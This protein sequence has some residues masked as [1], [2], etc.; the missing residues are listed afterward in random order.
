[1]FGR[2]KPVVFDRYAS[3][4]SR[5]IMPRWLWLLLFGAALGAGGVI[6]VQQEHLPQ[7]LS[8][9]ES[10]QL[11]TAFE[12]AESERTRLAAELAQSKLDRETALAEAKRLTDEL[13]VNQRERVALRGNIEAVL[14]S[15][16]PDPRGGAVEVRSARF[17][18]DGENLGFDIVLTR[19]AKAAATPFNGV[20]QFAVAGKTA[21]GFTRAHATVADPGAGRS[22]S[23]AVV[24][25]SC[26]TSTCCLTAAESTSAT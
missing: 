2:S 11:R 9:T 20:L 13:A 8:A 6:Y 21:R 15:L 22:A 5:S 16:P 14:D 25:R 19:A 7:R 17:D 26:W 1:M 18:V 12:S 23:A 10:G 3:R 4:R 24:R